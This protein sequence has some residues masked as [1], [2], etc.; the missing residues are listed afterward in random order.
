MI[1]KKQ[2][3]K[4]ILHKMG[5][6][7]LLL[8]YSTFTFSQNNLVSNPSFENYTSCPAQNSELYK[9]P[10]WFQPTQAT[11][12]YFNICSMG[13]WPSNMDVPTNYFGYQYARTESAYAGFASM[14]NLP[15]SFGLNLR[16]YVEGKLI[17]P[18]KKGNRYSV[19]FYVS[20]SNLSWYSTDAMGAFL[21]DSLV[22]FG[23]NYMYLLNAVPQISNPKG[24]VLKDTLN[25]MKV[26]GEFIAEGGERF[27]TI[28]NF[29]PDTLNT[30]DTLY[31][32]EHVAYYYVDDVSVIC[33]DCDSD[34]T[35]TTVANNL[36]IPDAFS[37]NGDGNN[38][39]LFVRG[40][41]IQELYFAVYIHISIISKNTVKRG[42]F[43]KYENNYKRRAQHQREG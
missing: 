20:L 10:P 21:G 25:W 26:S 6:L 32:Y 41:N 27:I 18:L 22:N 43:G 2:A 15:S 3:S 24:N 13:I 40:N 11:P 29:I 42:V 38:D 39:K 12:D 7:V 31:V 34:T 19:E 36:F 23:I 8:F 14:F 37:P 9:A 28:G 16:E 30:I 5:L 33:L 35:V 17:E 1:N 4:P